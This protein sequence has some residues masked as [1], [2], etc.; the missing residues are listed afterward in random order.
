M[1]IFLHYTHT[2]IYI[3]L[4][5]FVLK[6]F[7]HIYI[8]I[9]IYSVWFKTRGARTPTQRRTCVYVCVCVCVCVYVCVFTSSFI[10]IYA[11]LYVC[12]YIW[13]LSIV[14]ASIITIQLCTL[15]ASKSVNKT[16]PAYFIS[17][18]NAIKLFCVKC[19]VTLFYTHNTLFYL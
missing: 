9:Y 11:R 6:L 16:R 14:Y 10:H 4:H 15:L 13:P 1:L 12:G 17:T 8:Y 19:V 18:L 5:I 7:L 2:H 3:Y